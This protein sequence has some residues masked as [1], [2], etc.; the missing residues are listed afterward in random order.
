MLS[1]PQEPCDLCGHLG[2]KQVIR[3]WYKHAVPYVCTK[4]SQKIA[5]PGASLDLQEFPDKTWQHLN[6][7]EDS[8]LTWAPWWPRDSPG[9]AK[10]SLEQAKSLWG[11]DI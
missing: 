2:S 5:K 7:Q 8:G 11:R 3:L 1:L 9:I 10:M 4:A 6:Q